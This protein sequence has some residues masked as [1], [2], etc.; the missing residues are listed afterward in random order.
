M[1]NTYMRAFLGGSGFDLNHS[2]AVAFQYPQ[3]LI[4]GYDTILV[5]IASQI[6]V[7]SAQ[8]ATLDREL[9]FPQ[10]ARIARTY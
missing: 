4:D 5:A 8:I 6:A 10:S 3:P 7:S 2:S 9:A 1:I